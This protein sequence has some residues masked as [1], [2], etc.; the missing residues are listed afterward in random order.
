MY[1]SQCELGSGVWEIMAWANAHIGFYGLIEQFLLLKIF[2]HRHFMFRLYIDTPDVH[3]NGQ[4][5]SIF[6][7]RFQTTTNI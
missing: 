5:F 1:Q 3:Q 2:A 4:Q 6:P 7:E